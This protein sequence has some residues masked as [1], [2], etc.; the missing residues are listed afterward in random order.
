MVSV[1]GALKAL[2]DTGPDRISNYGLEIG[3]VVNGYI[4]QID[5]GK[6]DLGTYARIQKIVEDTGFGSQRGDYMSDPDIRETIRENM[7]RQELK[8]R[9]EKRTVDFANLIKNLTK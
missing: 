3:R 2:K 4:H 5:E 6:I 1:K 9:L 8:D 7:R